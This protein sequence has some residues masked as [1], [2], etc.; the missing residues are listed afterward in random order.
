M[1]LFYGK[2]KDIED[3]ISE[4]ADKFVSLIH[5]DKKLKKFVKV[6]GI[7]GPAGRGQASFGKS[8]V[9]FCC[10]TNTLNPLKERY[11]LKKFY[12][13]FKDIKYDISLL[14][15]APSIF[16]RKDLMFFEFATSGNFLYG[17]VNRDVKIRDIPK[18]EGIRLLTFKGDPF[19]A[20]IGTDKEEY[21]FSKLVL[22]IGESFLL[23]DNTY[24]ADDFKRKDLVLK[25]KYALKVSGFTE[26][27]K[28]AFDY[29][30][31][32]KNLGVNNLT[33]E[34]LKLWRT[35]WKIYL[36]NYFNCSYKDALK[37]LRM[38]KPSFTQRIGTRIFYTLNYWKYFK[39]IRFCFK[40]PFIQEVL[41][42]Q[43]Y[44]NNPSDK[45]K[46]KI[47]ESWKVAP[48]FWFNY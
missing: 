34:G 13:C 37:K 33:K 15:F 39:K 10:I 14:T 5:K 9:D 11:L 20:H 47:T 4:R 46:R 45:L 41:M 26:L 28:K 27:Y 18:W 40:E 36:E 24:V 23:L 2:K 44:F 35:A 29:R 25:N 38:V 32:G 8:D 48:R 12:E 3:K 16:K 7:T 1:K 31:S 22:G 6:F 19:L 30:Y 17:K 43:K 21:Y 42:I